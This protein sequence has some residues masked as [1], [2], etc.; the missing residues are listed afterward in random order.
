M[1][2]LS[3]ASTAFIWR[4]IDGGAGTDEIIGANDGSDFTITA[5][6]AGMVDSIPGFSSIEVLRGG[7]GDD[8]FNFMDSGSLTGWVMGGDGN[9]SL[10]GGE[11]DGHVFRILEPNEGE[12][13][14]KLGQGFFEVENLIGGS[15]DDTF[16]FINSDSF[17]DGTIDGGVGR[18]Q[19]SGDNNGTTFTATDAILA[20]TTDKLG[21]GFSRIEVLNGG[22]GDDI[23]IINPLFLGGGISGGAGNDTLITDDG[24]NMIAVIGGVNTGWMQGGVDDFAVRDNFSGIE[25]LNGGGGDD[26]IFID[27]N[28]FSDRI[29]GW[30][31]GR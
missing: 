29:R 25:N 15:G 2:A 26:R 9:D 1:T 23:F 12:I 11:L 5:T 24:D 28:W 10:V 4:D 22:D 31:N 30:W 19:L 21:N 16:D 18:D 27:S 7:P 17:L 13:A 8:N 14:A 20:G 3:S 6:D